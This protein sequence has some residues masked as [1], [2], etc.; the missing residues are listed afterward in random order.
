MW[1][2]N[3]NP[4][5]PVLGTMGLLSFRINVTLDGSVD[6]QQGIAAHE[7]HAFFTR[8]MDEGGAASPMR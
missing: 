2:R 7:T 5:L 3:L 4:Q 1:Y 8:L 6:D